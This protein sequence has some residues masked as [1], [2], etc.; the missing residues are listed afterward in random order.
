MPVRLVSWT[1]RHRTTG[2]WLSEDGHP[3]P[4]ADSARVFTTFDRADVFRKRYLDSFADA[5]KVE[6][7]PQPEPPKRAA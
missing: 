1:L 7:L 4:T 2:C 3:I 6:P 5:W